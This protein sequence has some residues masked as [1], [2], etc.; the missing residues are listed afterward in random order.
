MTVYRYESGGGRLIAVSRCMGNLF[1]CYRQKGTA[2]FKLLQR[3]LQLPRTKTRRDFT[4]WEIC[5]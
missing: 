3:R 2:P 4:G 5:S 1:K